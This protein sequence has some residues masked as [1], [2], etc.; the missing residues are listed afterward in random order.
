[1]LILLV[2]AAV[3]AA[4]ALLVA[5]RFADGSVTQW[6]LGAYVIA[7]SEIVLVSLLLSIQPHLTR[8]TLF[9][10][11]F[12]IFVV[13][14]AAVRWPRLPPVRAASRLLLELMRDPP[15]GL[16][17]V[18]FLG[19]VGYSIALGVFR[20]ANDGDAIE[21]HLARGAFWK[22][23]HT[24][25][26]IHGAAD[27]RIDAFPANAEI[28]MAFTMIL[29]GN[30]RFAPL[31]QLLAA[32]AT[33][34]AVYGI[35]RRIGIGVRESVFAALL[36]L[37]LPVFALQ[38]STGLN[39][40]VVASF[41]AIAVFFF[42]GRSR[43]D[44]VFGGLSVALLI[45]TKFTA[46]LALPL[47]AL[48]AVVAER[49]RWV[50][51]LSVIVVATVLG[52][53]WY[54]LNLVK[55]DHFLGAVSGQRG[56]T[57][58]GLETVARTLRLASDSF[59]LTGAIGL[60]RLFYV[61]A[62]IAVTTIALA[63]RKPLRDGATWATIAAGTTLAPLVLVAL[64]H[65]FIRA[66]SRLFSEIDR[67][68]F[69]WT[70]RSATKASPIFSWCG[71]LGVLLTLVVA[72]FVVRAVRRREL[73]PVAIAL[74][75]APAVAVVLLGIALP[76]YE[77]NGRYVAGSFALAV[78]TWGTALA[79][80][81]VAW[82]AAAL[83]AIT[84][85]LMFVHLHDRQSGIRLIEPTHAQSVWTLPSWSVEATDHPDLR[86]LF[87]YVTRNVPGRARLALEPNVYPGGVHTGGNLPPFPFFGSHLTRTILYAYSPRQAVERHADWAIL[88]DDGFGRCVP[89]W[90]ETFRYDVWVVLRRASGSRCG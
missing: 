26:Y 64:D 5:A 46:F 74:V 15:V 49:R 7:F 23:Q 25:G 62:A 10:A 48:V 43:A 21:Y 87:R 50:T 53:Y 4:T 33:G 72:C 63:A 79:V 1:M 73:P 22:Q 30:G 76:Y 39:D 6:L 70:A 44:L 14:V 69:A 41:V 83:A 17:G 75:A 32:I 71:P 77:W 84:S 3:V 35:S 57:G 54:V 45:G 88:R 42:L 67:P 66:V 28:G 86:E 59:E 81:P 37:T 12:V 80:R 9:T 16:L 51:V 60:D 18:V 27:G 40:V 58:G 19:V 68:Q 2:G 56:H 52:A 82:G 65:G 34:V 85:L 20:P 11:V 47:V 38:A 24:I 55:A 29:S 13:A 8:W 36:F 89:G 78:G 61:L 31:V 90:N